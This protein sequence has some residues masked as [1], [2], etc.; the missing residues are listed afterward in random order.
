MVDKIK[1]KKSVSIQRAQSLRAA[2]AISSAKL[3]ACDNESIQ[4]SRQ[5]TIVLNTEEREQLKKIMRE[6][7]AKMFDKDHAL[8]ESQ[9]KIIE[10]AVEMAIDSAN[11]EENS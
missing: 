3:R 5:A 2:S 10:Q 1:S 4:R 8:P 11:I 9:R 6:E 7:A